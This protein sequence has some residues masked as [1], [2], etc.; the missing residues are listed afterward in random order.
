MT[1][2]QDALTPI[3]VVAVLLSTGKYRN[4]DGACPARFEV[5]VLRKKRSRNSNLLDRL[6][7]LRVHNIT[8]EPL[9]CARTT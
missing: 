6:L 3:E 4:R 7:C 2:R 8:F 5:D 9:Q 1:M